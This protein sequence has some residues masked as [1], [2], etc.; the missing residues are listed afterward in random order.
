[1]QKIGYELSP[2]STHG[3]LR[4]IKGLTQA[5]INEMAKDNFEKEMA[6]H[7]AFFKKHEIFALIYTD[8]QLATIDSVFDDMKQYLTPV[9]KV[10]QLD[11]HLLEKFF[12]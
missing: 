2:W 5:Q 3:Y 6:K 7:R 9:D 4:K 10:V 1:M 11:F 8:K 12:A